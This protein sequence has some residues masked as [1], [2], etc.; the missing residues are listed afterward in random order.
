MVVCNHHSIPSEITTSNH[1]AKQQQKQ[2]HNP[3]KKQTKTANQTK[4]QHQQQKQPNTTKE[5]SKTNTNTHHTNHSA[6]PPNTC[7]VATSE[8]STC[9]TCLAYKSQYVFFPNS[10]V[11]SQRIK[12]SIYIEATART[13]RTFLCHITSNLWVGPLVLQREIETYN[14]PSELLQ[15][16]ELSNAIMFQ[17]G[18]FSAWN[19]IESGPTHLHL[20]SWRLK[21]RRI[22]LWPESSL[23]INFKWQ[24]DHK[25]TSPS[26]YVEAAAK[27]GHI[28]FYELGMP[29]HVSPK[30]MWF[31]CI[32]L[33]QQCIENNKCTTF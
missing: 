4:K 28:V 32:D 9:E 23:S 33:L 31:P 3:N 29:H 2:Q 14:D 30:S 19:W 16:H 20:W 7:E 15:V 24:F 21:D 17:G 27:T 1:A 18:R 10:Q 25:W 5:G 13:G 11:R 26:I 12:M 22:M 6:D 8:T